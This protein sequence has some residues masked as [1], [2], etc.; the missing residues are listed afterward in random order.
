MGN[1]QLGLE[2]S[3]NIDSRLAEN[4]PKCPFRNIARV[5][6]HRDFSA[7]LRVSPYLVAAWP[8]AIKLEAERTKAT[9]HLAIGKPG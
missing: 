8:L 2:K 3:A 1:A 7:S 6:R 5:V 9:D 4:R